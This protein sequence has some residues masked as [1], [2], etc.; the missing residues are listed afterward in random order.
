[1]KAEFDHGDELVGYFEMIKVP[2]N[3]DTP[4]DDLAYSVDLADSVPLGVSTGAFTE[5]DSFLVPQNKKESAVIEADAKELSAVM[6][7]VLATLTAALSV[8][9]LRYAALLSLPIL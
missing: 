5:E 1:M 6:T 3:Y 4:R 8:L 7:M 2:K 9:G